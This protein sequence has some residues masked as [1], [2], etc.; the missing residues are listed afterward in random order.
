MKWGQLM[1]K[2]IINLRPSLSHRWLNCTASAAEEASVP[3]ETS[4]YAEKGTL[5]HEIA[6]ALIHNK[7]DNRFEQLEPEEKEIIH[8]YISY[9]F[10]ECL[11]PSKHSNKPLRYIEEKVS[12]SLLNEVNST[13]T[14]DCII[15]D[16]GVG[17]RNDIH[18]LDFKTGKGVKIEAKNNPQLMI[19]ALAFLGCFDRTKKVDL[20][21]LPPIKLH[22]VQPA[23]GNS[24]YTPSKEEL[25]AFYGKV[26][27]TALNIKNGITE[28][29]EGS[30]CQFCAVEKSC[31]FRNQ[32]M[33]ETVS[34]CFDV[35]PR[36]KIPPEE[37]VRKK[38][39]IMKWIKAQEESVLA[40][41]EEGEDI[42][43]LELGLTATKR[44]F[45][46]AVIPE[47]YQRFGLDVLVPAG[48]EDVLK[49]VP[50]EERTLFEEQWITR[51]AGKLTIKITK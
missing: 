8:S 11:S 26:I 40:R 2:P 23:R 13:G 35:I 45:K 48:I 50:E 6:A 47:L 42:E 17:N 24:D 31:K 16:L 30:W 15:R 12:L 32:K 37:V 36:N 4:I 28:Y 18:I 3:R 7:T 25:Q 39:L 46:K 14:V 10:H 49:K 44:S 34:N 43:G 1:N 20:D 51:P 5:L 19:Y 41:M 33:L 21:N 22:I 29:K 27:A 38:P 9:I